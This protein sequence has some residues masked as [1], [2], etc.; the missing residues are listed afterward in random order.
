MKWWRAVKPAMDGV[1]K[2]MQDRV[3]SDTAELTANNTAL[4]MLVAQLEQLQGAAGAAQ[5]G[6]QCPASCLD[7][8]QYPLLHSA[9]CVCAQQALRHMCDLSVHARAL[10]GA[11]IAGSPAISPLPWNL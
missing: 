10:S 3:G 9:A 4:A 11:A 7:L 6:G 2:A 8:R 1:K 5:P